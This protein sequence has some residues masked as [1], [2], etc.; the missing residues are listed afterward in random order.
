MAAI[1]S[2]GSKS[3]EVQRVWEV[4]DDRL[5]YMARPDALV[6]DESLRVNDL[7]RAWLVWSG[8]AEAAL[9][10][11]CRFAGG[12]VPARG[13]IMGRGGARFRFGWVGP[14]FVRRVVMFSMFMRLV[15]SSAGST[16]L[17]MHWTP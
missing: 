10:D 8:A 5:Q 15:T 6:L 17:W 7:S 14:R 13:L 9:T 2:W 3:A 11:A 12:P 16:L 4:Y 1:D